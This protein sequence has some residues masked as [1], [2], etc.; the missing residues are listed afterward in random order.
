MEEK[1]GKREEKGERRKKEEKGE[2]RR[3]KGN[4][5]EKGEKG[6]IEEKRGKMGRNIAKR[7]KRW[8]KMTP[9]T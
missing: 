7:G 6:E 8:K 4:K 3:T 1:G 5:E 2:K 9:K